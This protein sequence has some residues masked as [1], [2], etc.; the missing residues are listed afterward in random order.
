MGSP[1]VLCDRSIHAGRRFASAQL[2]DRPPFRHPASRRFAIRLHAPTRPPIFDL[3]R[4]K[5][6]YT[7][8][9]QPSSVRVQ[10]DRRFYM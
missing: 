8:C 6:T 7:T 4:L 2:G 1:K 9:N 10:I 3:S 5:K